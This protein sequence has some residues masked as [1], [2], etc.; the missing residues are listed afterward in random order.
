[1][2]SRPPLAKLTRPLLRDVEPR[3][4]LFQRL[5]ELRHESPA[6][7][8]GAPAGSGKTALVVSYLEQG[9]LPVL[10]YRIDERDQHVAE[11]FFYLRLALEAM[12]SDPGGSLELPVFS[13]STELGRF[14]RRFFEALFL[15]LPRGGLLV[16]DDYHTATVGLEWQAAFEKC[17]A[18]IP[19]GLNVV[20]ISRQSPPGSLARAI[21]HRELG[22]LESSELLLS[23]QETAALAKR[24]L[25]KKQKLSAA[26]LAQIHAAT[27]GWAAGVSLLLRSNQ[28]GNLAALSGRRAEPLFDYLTN[29]VFS[30]LSEATQ[31]LLLHSACL[32]RFSL[33]ALE[34]LAGLRVD[35]SELLGLYRSGFFLESDGPGERLFRCHP[36]FRSFLSYRAEQLLGVEALRAA[37]ARAAD[38]LQNEGRGEEAVELLALI[39]DQPALCA[40]VASLAPS[41]FAQGRSA[42]LGEWLSAIASKSLE[43]SGWLSYWQASCLL[44]TEPSRS[45]KVFERALA[46]FEREQEGTGAYLAWAGAVQALVY[47]QR[48]FQ[49]LERWLERLTDLE[50][51]SPAFASAEVGAAVVS[52]LLL[53]L[54]FSGAERSAFARWTA[55]AMALAEKASDPSVR[56]MAASVLVFNFAMRGEAASAATW[57]AAFACYSANGPTPLIG[58]VAAR[59][60]ATTLAWHEG[61]NAAAVAAADEG[62]ALLGQNRVPMWQLALLLYGSLATLDRDVGDAGERFLA[63]LTEL[64]SS[65]TPLEVAGYH[66]VRA[67]RA[68]ARGEHKRALSCIELAIDL[69]RAVGFGQALGVDLQIAAHLH[70]ELGDEASGREALRESR[71][72]EETHRHPGLRYWR[73]LIEADRALRVGERDTAS[74][75]LREAFTAGQAQQIFNMFC[76]GPARVAELCRFAL[77]H[78][79]EPE[80]ACN[81][82]RRK[83]LFQHAAPVELLSW[84]WPIRI[85]TFGGL[86]V[87]LDDKPLALGRV[88]T[89]LLLLRLLLTTAGSRAGMPVARVLASLW[90]ESDGDNA[91][92]AFDMTVLRLRGQLGEQGRKALRVERGHVLLDPALCWTDTMALS[93]L[94]TE[95]AGSGPQLAL[96]AC[97]GLADRLEQLYRGPFA[98]EDDVASPLGDYGERVR[99]KVSGALSTLNAHFSR[100]GDAQ[101][102]AALSF[103]L[104]GADPL[105]RVD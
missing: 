97:A 8:I 88:R 90:P 92:H 60:A 11:L 77:A 74:T 39:D 68:L 44:A 83:E 69:D 54:T 52:S 33:N 100:L 6:L 23:E 15:R 14:S 13:Q 103:R 53:G 71:H 31:T 41:L 62:L 34:E 94:L 19:D 5:D 66:H 57:L 56:A 12:E 98:D 102:G 18:S 25:G 76:P 105:L 3:T 35:H 82:V 59:A 81:L 27:S 22:V 104:R 78:D 45:L 99:V 16:F 29:A 32:R 84:P 50:R 4:R 96:E 101:Q 2:S 9:E 70:F 72:I 48:N 67:C 43:A 89:P 49:L 64:A 30:E 87:R 28:G 91:E 93:A 55:R 42:M 58:Q 80:Y 10:W 24:R 21:A 75:L 86:D 73:L 85:R 47:E 95:I 63:R 38:M 17:L 36:L 79:I 65:S 20:V 61:R 26:E 51:F 46:I 37:R 7:W 1:M 40:L